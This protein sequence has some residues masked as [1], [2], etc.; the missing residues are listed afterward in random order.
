M[1]DLKIDLSLYSERFAQNSEGLLISR[2]VNFSFGKNGTGKTT[3]ADAIKS[4]HSGQ[5]DVC[6]F[7]DF[8]GVVKHFLMIFCPISVM[9]T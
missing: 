7:D 8:D 5:Y 6:I 3:L 4:Q 2:K 1:N 9:R